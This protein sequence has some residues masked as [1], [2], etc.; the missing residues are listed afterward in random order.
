MNPDH[1][2]PVVTECNMSTDCMCLA[3]RGRADPHCSHF[4]KALPYG[5][6]SKD[7]PHTDSDYSQVV[8]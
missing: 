6:I 4:R 2:H 8:S 3:V 1:F 5:E 7:V